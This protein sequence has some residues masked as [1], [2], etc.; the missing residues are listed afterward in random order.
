MHSDAP[1]KKAGTGR[2]SSAV[3]NCQG[4]SAESS[5]SQATHEAQSCNEK[6]VSTPWAREGRTSHARQNRR[7]RVKS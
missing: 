3:S 7:S 1:S 5:S 2:T 6:D 4:S